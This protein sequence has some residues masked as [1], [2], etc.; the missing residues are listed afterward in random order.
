MIQFTHNSCNTLRYCLDHGILCD[1][2]ITYNSSVYRCHKAI[3]RLNSSLL[4]SHIDENLESFDCPESLQVSNDVLLSLLRYFYGTCLDLTPVNSVEVLDLSR[5]FQCTD[6][7]NEVKHV[8]RNFQENS[9]QISVSGML[10]TMFYTI[11]SDFKII[12]KNCHLNLHRF[13]LAAYTKFF[14]T[15]WS[16]K[17]EASESN[18][19]DFSNEL[20]VNEQVFKDFFTS[21]YTGTIT[22]SVDNIFDVYHL[23]CIFG[24]PDLI[25]FCVDYIKSADNNTEWI[26]SSLLKSDESENLEFVKEIALKLSKI[27]LKECHGIVL[28]P[29]TIKYLSN[30]D[31][32]WVL[33]CIV[34]SYQANSLKSSTENFDSLWNSKS[35]TES[36]TQINISSLDSVVLFATIKSLFDLKETFPCLVQI[37]I[38]LIEN[39]PL[40][41][42]L[43]WMLLLIT[44]ADSQGDQETTEQL[45][46]KLEGVCTIE[47]CKKE[48]LSAIKLKASTLKLII[49]ATSSEHLVLWSIE[50]ITSSWNDSLL[51][52]Q[53]VEQLLPLI[54]VSNCDCLEVYEKLATLSTVDVLEICV[55]KY[56]TFKVMSEMVKQIRGEHRRSS[57]LFRVRFL[58]DDMSD[59]EIPRLGRRAPVTPHV[60]TLTS[61]L[62]S[63]SDDDLVDMSI[64]I[65]PPVALSAASSA[66]NLRYDVVQNKFITQEPEDDSFSSEEDDFES[67]SSSVNAMIPFDVAIAEIIQNQRK[68][69]M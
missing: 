41:F 6:L 29:S 3:V 67:I 42:P 24:V 18:E 7:E 64:P 30:V 26:F 9:A 34:A 27:D 5:F 22:V 12:Y 13:I 63:S 68:T 16:R 10:N 28:R 31:T 55:C 23:A 48:V 59:L 53:D 8:I 66:N 17:W 62:P 51:S 44:S 25:S 39:N 20:L 35:L 40:T 54:K 52:V 46:S 50:S 37:S 43:E 49:Q 19:S 65:S 14:K 57:Q 4:E 21:F 36:F 38:Q 61:Q 47:K 11:D 32:I 15:K 2:T 56:L 45:S 58:K 1:F 69:F 60:K 33:K